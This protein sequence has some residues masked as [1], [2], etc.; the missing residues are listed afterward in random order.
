MDTV[1]TYV[2]K[3]EIC[4]VLSIS[5][6]IRFSFEL[7]FV[8]RC[9]FCVCYSPS[10]YPSLVPDYSRTPSTGSF[11]AKQPVCMYSL[12]LGLGLICPRSDREEHRS[13]SRSAGFRPVNRFPKVSRPIGQEFWASTNWRRPG[14]NL[15]CK[16][17][18]PDGSLFAWTSPT[19]YGFPLWIVSNLAESRLSMRRQER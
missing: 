16:A 4:K 15:R 5:N 13:N 1:S 14:E 19:E 6:F 12:P 2:V 9:I 3:I 8:R 7:L 18:S 10:A 17:Y 11:D